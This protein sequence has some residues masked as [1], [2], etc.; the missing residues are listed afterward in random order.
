MLLQLLG[1]IEPLKR[2]LIA[3]EEDQEQIERVVQL[4]ERMNPTPKPLES[5]LLNGR[6]RLVRASCHKETA[7][8]APN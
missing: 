2:G 5:S 8:A 3:T 1:L 6:W 4:L 7:A